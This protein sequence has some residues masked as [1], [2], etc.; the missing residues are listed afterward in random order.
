MLASTPTG[1]GLAL[2][3]LAEIPGMDESPRMVCLHLHQA[4][5]GVGSWLLGVP[6]APK[7]GALNLYPQMPSPVASSWPRAGAGHDTPLRFLGPISIPQGF[8]P[9]PFPPSPAHPREL[10]ARR[11]ARE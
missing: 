3:P 1:A 6:A 2:P 9:V 4:G 8:L 5:L 11:Q 10:G 7:Q